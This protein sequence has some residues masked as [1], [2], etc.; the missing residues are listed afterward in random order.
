MTVRDGVLSALLAGNGGRAYSKRACCPSVNHS[1]SEMEMR[2]DYL[3]KDCCDH[4][5]VDWTAGPAEVRAG[6]LIKSFFR[7]LVG[8]NLA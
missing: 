8:S 7:T 5:E 4:S 1:V 3:A 6:R 2:S